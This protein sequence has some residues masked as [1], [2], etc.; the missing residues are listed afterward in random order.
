MSITT[1]QL[2]KL[3]SKTKEL[4][5]IIRENLNII[6]EK[7]LHSDKSWGRNA[8]TH[9][10]PTSFIFIYGIKSYLIFE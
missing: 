9:D 3:S 10:L 7:L 2:S 4:N 1:K 5:A 8:I 6:D